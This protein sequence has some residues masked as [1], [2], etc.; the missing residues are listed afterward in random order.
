VNYEGA[1]TMAEMHLS[2]DANANTLA[3][4]QKQA[5]LLAVVG[6]SHHC[7]GQFRDENYNAANARTI[8]SLRPSKGYVSAGKPDYI[9]LRKMLC[10]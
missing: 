5:L 9:R 1:S 4:Y 7:V 8:C 3:V 6:A 2:H 10:D